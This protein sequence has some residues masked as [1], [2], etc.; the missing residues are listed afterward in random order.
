MLIRR[1]TTA[2]AAAVLLLAGMTVSEARV[3]IDIK[4]DSTEDCSVA[5]NARVEQTKWLTVGWYVYAA[6]E[7]APIIL[8]E[9]DDVRQVYLYHD[10]NLRPADNDEVRLGWVKIMYR[11]SDTVPMDNQ[12]GYEEVTFVRLQ[13]NGRF[14]IQSF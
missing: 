1:L 8:D 13:N 3:R 9:V 11:F 6:G 14:T 5:L 4:N 12:T 2:A 7:E 10:C